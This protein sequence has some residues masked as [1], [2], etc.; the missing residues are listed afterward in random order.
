M[1][2]KFTSAVRSLSKSHRPSSENVTRIASICSRISR[3]V[4]LAY[5]FNCRIGN[6]GLV[7]KVRAVTYSDNNECEW[8]AIC[9]LSTT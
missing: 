2:L 7:L 3:K 6:E 8:D 4:Y 9:S 1:F 5:N